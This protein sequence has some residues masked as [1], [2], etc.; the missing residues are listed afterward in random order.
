[1]Q[2]RCQNCGRWRQFHGGFGHGFGHGGFGH[3]FGHGF[4]GFGPG[5]GLGFLIGLGYPNYYYDD[6]YYYYY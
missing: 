3:G 5:L 2:Y 1:M 6:D 4:G